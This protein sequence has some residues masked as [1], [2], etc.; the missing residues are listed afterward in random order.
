MATPYI[1]IGCPTTGGGKVLTGN[2]AFLVEG[3][4]IACVG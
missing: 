2:S 1:T 4:P 3:I